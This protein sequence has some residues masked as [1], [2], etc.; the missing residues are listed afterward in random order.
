MYRITTTL[1]GR[2][3][4]QKYGRYGW[5]TLN[6]PSYLTRGG[7]RRR[8]E[9]DRAFWQRASRNPRVVEYVY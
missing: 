4:A 2:F 7:A 6:S 8:I 5:F 3:R 1:S 9:E